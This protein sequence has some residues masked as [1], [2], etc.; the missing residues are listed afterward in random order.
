[1]CERSESKYKF[2]GTKVGEAYKVREQF[3]TPKIEN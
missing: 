3:I 2:S 1:M